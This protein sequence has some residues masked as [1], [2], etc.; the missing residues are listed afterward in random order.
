MI[1]RKYNYEPLYKSFELVSNDVNLNDNFKA[2]EY[3][4]TPGEFSLMGYNDKMKK[5]KEDFLLYKKEVEKVNFPLFIYV[6]EERFLDSVKN[7]KDSIKKVYGDGPFLILKYDNKIKKGNL[8]DF[9]KV[10]IVEKENE[11]KINFV[12]G[13]FLSTINRDPEYESLS[14]ILNNSDDKVIEDFFKFNYGNGK[15]PRKSKG[16]H[17]K[18]GHYW[19]DFGLLPKGVVYKPSENIKEEYEKINEYLG[20]GPKVIKLAFGHTA[21]GYT[22]L[23]YQ[24]QQKF[25]N[26]IKKIIEFARINDIEPYLIIQETLL[27][28]FA[29]KDDNKA[30]TFFVRVYPILQDDKIKYLISFKYSGTYIEGNQ[31]EIKNKFLKIYSRGDQKFNLSGGLTGFAYFVYD[32]SNKKIEIIENTS[33]SNIE[34][35]LN[36]SKDFVYKNGE[37]INLEEASAEIADNGIKYLEN[38]YKKV[39]ELA[40]EFKNNENLYDDKLKKLDNILKNNKYPIVP[41]DNLKFL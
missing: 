4:F 28:F 3:V 26:N 39:S 14:S 29:F 36:L 35:E 21:G 10:K 6:V 18:L 2:F 40:K 32:P 12:D 13:V 27:P 20:K 17:C 31:E 16:L 37:K 15:D 30:Y 7:L 8:L 23:P 41:T 25:E 24:T 9:E 1:R 19:V 11:D 38:L 33:K 5:L 34:T 22:V